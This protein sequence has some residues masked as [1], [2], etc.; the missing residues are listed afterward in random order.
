MIP[1]AQGLVT[2]ESFTGELGQVILGQ[3]PGRTD[4]EQITLFKTVGTAV[5]D[6]VTAQLIYEKAL[7]S[8]VGQTIAL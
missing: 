5:L 6:V 3:V 1:L 8:H 2:Q 7:A 4:A